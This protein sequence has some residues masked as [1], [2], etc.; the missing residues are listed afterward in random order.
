MWTDFVQRLTNARTRNQSDVV[1]MLNPRVDRLPLPIQRYDDPFFPFGKEIVRAT[2]QSV[3]AYVFDLA[4][5]LALGAAGARL[6]CTGHLW[7]RVTRQWR[8]KP[9][10]QWMR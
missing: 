5:Y 4:S 10:L 8:T 1:L 6:F 9:R 2:H 3:C 7:G